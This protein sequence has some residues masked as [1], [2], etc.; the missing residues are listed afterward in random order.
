MNLASLNFRIELFRAGTRYYTIQSTIYHRN[1]YYSTIAENF[2]HLKIQQIQVNSRSYHP[3]ICTNF[4]TKHAIIVSSKSRRNFFN[5]LK[6][7]KLLPITLWLFATNVK[8]L[9]LISLHSEETICIG[10][11]ENRGIRTGNWPGLHIFARSS[12]MLRLEIDIGAYTY[13]SLSITDAG[14][15]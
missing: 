6:N 5:N 10:Q 13:T 7:N 12:P 9:F 15:Y 1:A 2:F 14:N 3:F 8:L 11:R 4:N